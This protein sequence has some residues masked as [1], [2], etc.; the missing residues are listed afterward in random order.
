MLVLGAGPG[1]YS[2]AFRSATRHDDGLVERYPTLGGVCLNVAASPRRR[3][4]PPPSWTK[5]RQCATQRLLEPQIDIASCAV[6]RRRLIGQLTGGLAGM[7]KARKISVLE[8]VE[9][10]STP[11]SR[12]S[13]ETTAQAQGRKVRQGNIAAGSQAIKLPFIPDDPRRGG[14]D[15]RPG[16][17][18]DSQN[19]CW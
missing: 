14:F 2:A 17:C 6:T 11:T 1:G 5:S 7:A 16:N 12:V 9:D 3:C 13:S 8:G 15:R 19:R 18:A 4:T 10:F